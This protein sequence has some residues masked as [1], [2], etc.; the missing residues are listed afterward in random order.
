MKVSLST[1]LGL[2]W[3][4][5]SANAQSIPNDSFECPSIAAYAYRPS[6]SW[7]FTGNSEIQHNGSA[8]GAP[9][10]PDG[11]QTAFLQYGTNPSGGG[12]ISQIF[13]VSTAGTY[14][15]SFYS[16]LRAYRTS[17]TIMS[18]RVTVDGTNIG[19]FSPTSTA[20]SKFTTDP[21]ALSAGSHTLSF[22]GTGAA[23]D[24]SD[25]IDFVT[26]NSVVSNSA[27]YVA[28]N[29]SDGDPGTLASPFATLAKAQTA[30]RNSSTT[31]TTYI[32]AGTYNFTTMLTLTS[33][34][35]GEIWSVY[36]PD[37]YNTAIL[38]AKN[39][40]FSY[41]AQNGNNNIILIKGGSNIT[42]NGLTLQNFRNGAYGGGSGIT[43]IGTNILTGGFPWPNNTIGGCQMYGS[44]SGSASGNTI[45]N[46]IID[47]VGA[48]WNAANTYI[49][50]DAIAVWGQAPN[51]MISHNV[52]TNTQGFGI[53]A[54][55][56]HPGNVAGL[57][58]TNNYVHNTDLAHTDDTG[59]IYF[60]DNQG[61]TEIVCGTSTNI[62]IANNY[63]RDAI[64]I[65]T[66]R[67]VGG[68]A[69]GVTSIYLDDWAAGV[70]VSGNVTTG[71][72]SQA[73]VNHG[74]CN[75]T[76]TNNI[77]DLSTFGHDYVTIYLAMA[78][79][80]GMT[81]NSYTNN[82]V[83]GRWAGAGQFTN[84][85]NGFNNVYSD[86]GSNPPTLPTPPTIGNSLYFNYT[87]GG[88]IPVS[89][90]FNNRLIDHNP[91]VSNP[92]FVSSNW[93]FTL[94]S[95]SP[96]HNSPVSF[97]TPSGWGQPGF[98]GPVGYVIPNVGTA[99]SYTTAP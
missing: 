7:T 5:S 17:S 2:M 90:D 24:T 37:G 39:M 38:D 41:C 3:L 83:V 29:G 81:G 53:A 89:S 79:G 54:L 61:Q 43:I 42:I 95:N 6:S 16:A 58:I 67:G 92:G 14:S 62:N 20:F 27:F 99:P 46:N 75:N 66:A 86:A 10:A 93:T 51:T 94:A 8:W 85:L 23:A 88:S 26:L 60:S 13:N 69:S 82:I 70:K 28:T 97:V 35:N 36:T 40:V 25:F 22:V 74:G 12:T 64:D 19:S 1:A 31:K 55:E 34:D 59:S 18:F 72:M 45:T 77:F 57:T 30:M 49:W 47:N 4:V 76:I 33:A 44:V 98:W 80:G 91:T 56:M 84:N 73:M 78:A 32:R 52:V 65:D 21:I 48:T 71:Y 96:A 63:I 11:V 68:F 9:N 50:V 15:V 87:S